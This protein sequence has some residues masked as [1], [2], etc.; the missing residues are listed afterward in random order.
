M[1]MKIG[2]IILKAQKQLGIITSYDYGFKM[3]QH[4]CPHRNNFPCL[5]KK[6]ITEFY[7]PVYLLSDWPCS[8]T[9]KAYVKPWKESS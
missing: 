1:K 9:G 2:T 4:Y 5:S 6:T 7:Y 3:C 8:F